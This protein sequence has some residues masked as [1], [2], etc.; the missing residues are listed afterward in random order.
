MNLFRLIPFLAE[1]VAVRNQN[2]LW[3][4][5]IMIGIAILFFYFI[6]WRPEKKRRKAMEDKRSA[7]KKG[8]RV[9]AMGIVGTLERI[10]EQTVIVKMVDG[11][12]IEFIK[13]AISEV[14]PMENGIEEEKEVK[15]E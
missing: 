6:L 14:K 5:M 12:K 3:Q 1:E 11:T 9:T 7:M 15:G 8:D 4:T 10:K 13:G 2:S